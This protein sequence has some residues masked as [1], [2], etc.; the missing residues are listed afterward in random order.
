MSPAA[1][2]LFVTA[3]VGGLALLAQVARKSRGAEVTLIVTLLALSLLVAALCAF[4]GVGLLLT[5]TGGDAPGFE[6]LTFV[7]AGGAGGLL[8]IVRARLC[9]SPLGPGMGGRLPNPFCAGPPTFPAL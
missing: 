5:A 7:A 2:T 4:T 6:R 1:L 3:F 9:V 8:G